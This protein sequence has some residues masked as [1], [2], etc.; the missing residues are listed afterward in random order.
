M[1]TSINKLN[2]PA[3]I[4]FWVRLFGSIMIFSLLFGCS[5]EISAQGINR[6]IG[7]GLRGTVWKHNSS[8]NSESDFGSVISSDGSGELYFF[9]RLK[10]QWFL[11]TSIGGRD[12]SKIG[13]GKVESLAIIPFLFGARYD[14]LSPR[15]NSPY[16]PYLSFGAG[17]YWIS[18]SLISGSVISESD[19]QMGLFFGG[20]LNV[21][22]KNWFAL[23]TDIK[24]HLVNLGS[25]QDDLSGLQLGIGFSFMWG[26]KREIFRIRETKLIVRDIYP[27]YYQFYNTYP[28]AL[29]TIENTA[30]YPIEVNLRCRVTPYSSRAKES[31]F[32]KIDK[33]EVR[34]LPATAIFAPEITEVSSTEPA[35][36][37]IEV[38]G[39]AGSTHI[40]EISSQITVH[41]RNSWNGEMDKLSFFV[42]PDNAQIIQFGRNLVESLSYSLNPNRANLVYAKIIFDELS[43][44]GIHYLSDPNIPFY[45]DDRVQYANET[46]KLGSGDCDDLVV[47]YASLLESLGINTAF[48]QVKDPEKEQAHIYIIFDTAISA[49]YASEISTNEKRYIIREKAPGKKTVWIPIETT[50]IARGFDDA[51]NLGALNYL[52]EVTLR[53]G[54]SEGWIQIFDVE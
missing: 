35:V 29:V 19:A 54:I 53:N 49:E 42:T 3:N 15:Y 34:D 37:D 9:H 40:Q 12:K 26:K 27:A 44:R 32:I 14:L 36:L 47:L 28:I 30:G 38:E 8:A 41:T 18:R 25:A 22:L 4:N 39:R 43:K 51:W 11:E 13:G 48:V 52:N 46:L 7:L 2:L 23:N 31:G 21:I 16:Q 6:S 17:T 1:K 50:L 33:G 20:G 45:Q 10:E 5:F 24:Y